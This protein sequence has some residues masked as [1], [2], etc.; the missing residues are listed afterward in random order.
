[1][2]S[3]LLGRSWRRR[4]GR[5]MIAPSCYDSSIWRR[6]I[7]KVA[8]HAL[9]KLLEMK[10]C[11]PGFLG[12]LKALHDHT[13][14]HVRFDGGTSAEFVPD[15]GLREGCPSSPVLFN[16]YHH[17]I[18]EVFQARRARAAQERQRT[19]G[20]TWNYKVDGKIGKRRMDRLEEGR[21]TRQMLIGD[22]AYADDTGILGDADEVV[23]AEGLFASTLAD[24][25]GK[26]NAGKT[27]GLR[28]TSEAPA[29]Y[30][31]PHCGEV[32]AVRHV[33]DEKHAASGAHFQ[34]VDSR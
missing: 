21:N 25:A 27:E 22:F 31:I 30:D 26:V 16:L 12:V 33:S 13:A 18:M 19:P 15:R 5:C 8:R 23:T 10:G 7:P 17:G 32:T 1:M 34:G 2:C 11:P 29:E 6:R 3:R 24:F 9:W 14:S 4:R 28:V 20:V